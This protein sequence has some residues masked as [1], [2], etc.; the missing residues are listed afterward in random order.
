MQSHDDVS[1]EH[2]LIPGGWTE[3]TITCGQHQWNILLPADADQF[4]YDLEY[5]P[6]TEPEPDIYWARL[7][8]V[9]LTLSKLVVAVRPWPAHGSV[10]ELGC[11]IG[12]VGVAALSAGY[13]VTMSD[14]VKL[15]IDLAVLNAVRNGWPNVRSM[16]LDWNSPQPVSFDGIVGSDILYDRTNHAKIINVVKHMLAPNGI[17][18][19]ADPGRYHLSHFLDMAI[20]HGLEVRLR[21]EAGNYVPSLPD[22]QFH[23]VEVRHSGVPVREDFEH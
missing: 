9:S 20:E 4:L 2:C 12:L 18:W 17:A 19:F 21:T 3:Q 8:P 16:L 6:A 7:W 5:L 11:G 23:L 13:E 22:N 15:A 10:L 1:M 14:Y